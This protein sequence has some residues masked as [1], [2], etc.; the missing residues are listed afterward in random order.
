MKGALILLAASLLS[1]ADNLQV[2][3]HE[4]S[5]PNGNDWE[6]Q[7]ESGVPVLHMKIG[8]EPLPSG[9]RRPFQ[10]ALPTPS[11]SAK[12]RLKLTSGH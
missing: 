12:W 5:V 4:W 10:F 8:R 6:I 1:A 11:R 2:F 3:S 7:N 9:P